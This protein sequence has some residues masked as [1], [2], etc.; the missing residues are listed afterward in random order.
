MDIPSKVIKSEASR[1]E[2]DS[3]VYTRYT[4]LKR[5]FVYFIVHEAFIAWRRGAVHVNSGC[6]VAQRIRLSCHGQ[7]GQEE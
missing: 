2:I 7:P 5:K 6:G 1:R 3:M 4:T